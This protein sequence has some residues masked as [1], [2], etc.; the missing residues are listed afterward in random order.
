MVHSRRG[1]SVLGLLAATALIFAACGGGGSGGAAN[2]ETPAEPF[3]L[4]AISDVTVRI[5][6]TEDGQPA[7]RKRVTLSGVL[8]PPG[9]GQ[10]IEDVT[11]GETF[12]TGLTDLQGVFETTIR[13]PGQ[14]ASVDVIVIDRG[15]TGP[16]THEELRTLW[17]VFAP[18]SRVTVALE[19]LETYVVDLQGEV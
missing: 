15:W 8:V 19:D 7:A 2:L 12:A 17:G 9:Q 6:V 11:T 5:T 10:E 1:R 3:T 18:A 13:V 16:Y 14:Y 4:K